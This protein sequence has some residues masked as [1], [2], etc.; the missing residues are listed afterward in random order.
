MNKEEF[1]QYYQQMLEKTYLSLMSNP[2]IL[3]HL[4][5]NERDAEMIFSL[6][7]MTEMLAGGFILKLGCLSISSEKLQDIWERISKED[8]EK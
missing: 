1:A 3:P 8:D 6:M 5:K 4:I 7:K 2:N